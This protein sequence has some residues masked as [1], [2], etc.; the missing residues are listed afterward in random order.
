MRVSPL[1]GAPLDRLRAQ[2][3][4]AQGAACDELR[5]HSAQRLLEQYREVSLLARRPWKLAPSL[6]A[7]RGI[8]LLAPLA[9]R[10]PLV[11]P[12]ITSGRLPTLAGHCG[13]R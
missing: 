7:K 9:G 1:N 10:I 11:A 2:P 8:A 12:P 6:F 5:R 13:V 4:Q 3:S